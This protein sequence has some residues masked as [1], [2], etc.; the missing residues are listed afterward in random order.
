[1]KEIVLPPVREETINYDRLESAIARIFKEQIYLPLVVAVGDNKNILSNASSAL[2]SALRSGRIQFYRG[3]FSGK[4]NAQIT[5][6]LRSIGAKW[7]RKNKKYRLQMSE[8]PP[9][10][11]FDVEAS[12]LMLTRRAKKLETALQKMSPAK[13]AGSL[14][15]ED[16]FSAFIQKADKDIVDNFKAVGV[17]PEFTEETKG[18]LS[19]EYNKNMQRY[20]QDWT[21]KEIVTL[22]NDV[23][24]YYK[25][26]YR[27]KTLSEIIEKR[28]EVSQSKAKFL[29]RQETRLMI[30]KF[31][32]LRYVD[33]GSEGY[34]W[35]TVVGDAGSPVRPMHKKL[36][37]KFI[38]WD[39]PPITNPKGDRNHAGEDYN[40][41]CTPRAVIRKK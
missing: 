8:L 37:G 24:K 35:T 22:R 6:D 21:E 36:A 10:I 38:R 2:S 14:K 5:K 33:L 40:C 29:A 13:I 11:R 23:Q 9:Q 25:R 12:D 28:Y 16:I 4:L 3:V 26:G 1:M 7:D 31:R 18:R 39:N 19:S 20:I 15:S 27:A 41:R 34:Y 17:A 32:E 30:S